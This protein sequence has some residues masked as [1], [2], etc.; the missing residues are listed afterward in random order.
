[1]QLST[2]TY[3]QEPSFARKDYMHFKSA[4]VVLSR[5]YYY[6]FILYYLQVWDFDLCHLFII[7]EMN[8]MW[9][10]VLNPTN[11]SDTLENSIID[12]WLVRSF[13]YPLTCTVA[14]S[15][16]GNFLCLFDWLLLTLT[17]FRKDHEKAEFEVHEVYAVDVLISTGEGK[18]S[19]F[20]L[21]LPLAVYST[22]HMSTV[23]ENLFSEKK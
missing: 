21:S 22:E 18:V 7:M 10:V 5:K 12:I 19:V 2:H 3:I 17:F 15:T 20:C 14:V 11:H 6:F 23:A 1:M 4:S 8:G 9:F 16:R 13:I